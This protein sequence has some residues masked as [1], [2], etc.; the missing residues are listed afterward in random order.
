MKLFHA[1]LL[2]VITPIFSLKS[3]NMEQSSF[4]KLVNKDT[5]INQDFIIEGKV[6]DKESGEIVPYCSIYLQNTF[7]GTST[8]EEG[9]F[10]LRLDSIPIQLVFSHLSY[11]KQI[12]EVTNLQNIVIE[13]QPFINNLNEV[14]LETKRK[15]DRY[16][17]NLAKQALN[18][19]RNFIGNKKYGKALYRQKSKNGDVYTE[20]SEI[21][22][23]IKYDRAGIED[24]EIEEGRY[25]LKER[26][27]RN[28][29]FTLLSRILKL[30]QPDT[31]DIYFPLNFNL[32]A[33]YDI[34]TL[35]KIKTDNGEMAV[36]LF[37]PRSDVETPIFEGKLTIDTATFD[38]LKVEGKI[39]RDDLDLIGFTHKNSTKKNYNIAYEIVYRK[40]SVLDV[41]IDN[42]KVNQSF[43]YYLN[44]VIQTNVETV[45]NLTFYEYYSPVNQKKLGKSYRGQSDWQKL[46]LIGYNK[47]FWEDNPIVKRTPIE[48]EVIASFEKENSF[49]SI[50]LNSRDQIALSQT[51]ISDDPFIVDL[52]YQLNEYNATTP[53]EKI[54]VHT[55]KESYFPGEEIR[56][57]AFTV[58][59]ANHYYTIGSGVFHV[60]LISPENKILKA[61]TQ[62]LNMGR[63]SG[64]I[65]ISKEMAPGVYQ[66]RCYTN[67]M[68]NFESEFFFSKKITIVN[69]DKNIQED[70][71]TEREIDL[72]FFPEGGYAVNGLNNRIAFKAIGTDGYGKRV[73]GKIV[74]SE[75]NFIGNIKSINEGAG[76]FNLI[77]KEGQSYFAILNNNKKYAL[78]AAQKEGYVMFVNNSNSRSVKVRVDATNSL[79]NKLFYVVGNLRN[80]KFYQGKF[81]FED[82]SYIEF[83][84]PKKSLPSGV[85]TITLFDENNRVWSERVVFVNNNEQ[86]IVQVKSDKET[87][88]PREKISLEVLVTDMDGKPVSTDLSIAVTDI[89]SGVKNINKSNIITN[90]LLESDIK[91]HI[92]NPGQYFDNSKRATVSKLDLMMLTHGW[93]KIKWNKIVDEIASIKPYQFKKG[94]SV[95]GVATDLSNAPLKHSTLNLLAKSNMKYSVYSTTSNAYGSFFIDDIAHS[96]STQLLF[97]AIKNNIP[98]KIKVELDEANEISPLLP[99]PEY[100]YRGNTKLREIESETISNS[101]IQIANNNFYE[102]GKITPLNEV[103]VI[104][105]A[106]EIEEKSFILG[107]IEPDETVIIEEYQAADF[108]EQL[109]RVPGINIIG[110]GLLSRVSIRGSGGPL[111]VVDGIPLLPD[112]GPDLL[113]R[114]STS[115]VGVPS[116]TMQPPSYIPAQIATMNTDNIERIEVLKGGKAAMFGMYANNGAILIYTKSGKAIVNDYKSPEFLVK[117]YSGEKEFYSPKYDVKQDRHKHPDFRSTLYWK[118]SIEIDKNGK[119][120]IEFYNSDV[121]TE[122]QVEIETLSS[123]GIPGYFLNSFGN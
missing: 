65:S 123:Y 108:I 107:E 89:N 84:I 80:T 41:V 44:D 21:M 8:N 37:K 3:M 96:D 86:L 113:G 120:T 52:T 115:S 2:F 66:L 56:Y 12:F 23:D 88:L 99:L 94:F 11:K 30:V 64:S 57:S 110:S 97:T 59:G 26:G 60:D 90:L 36:L 25:A 20:L 55:N 104:G 46:N 118:S 47:K 91:G 13:L 58:L 98:L 114:P 78:P 29:N 93:R 75:D 112:S 71:F 81:K 5:I 49:E 18:K 72:Q 79:K 53:V 40:D 33:L 22:F 92:E 63:G 87:Y 95:S 1:L 31:E 32:D 39:A 24:W 67:W 76:F 68:R 106:R 103:E 85:M 45:S 61:Q 28:N 9:E 74:D 121:N 14:L 34:R 111:W 70:V 15:K 19:T 77:P 35:K 117:G 6:I 73:E 38:V 4:T 122:F 54:Y 27:V 51:D 116:P 50:Y 10:I 109:S 43:D 105:K 100:K 7:K 48:K 62:S 69:N 101:E 102:K 17:L 119:A 16:A 82:E 42:I 83:E